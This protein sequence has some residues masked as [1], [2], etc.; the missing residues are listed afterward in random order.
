MLLPFSLGG[1]SKRSSFTLV[2]RPKC[3]SSL[4]KNPSITKRV[5]LIA[6]LKI[7]VVKNQGFFENCFDYFL[8]H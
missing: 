4:I 7:V 5:L 2:T 3:L 6:I 1:K 8:M